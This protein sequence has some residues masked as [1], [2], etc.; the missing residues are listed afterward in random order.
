MKWEKLEEGF[1]TRREPGTPTAVAAGSRCAR[2]MQGDLVCTYMVQSKLG[3]NDFVPTISRSADQ[4]R[5][6][7]EQGPIWPQLEDRFSYFVSVSRAPSGDLFLYGLE[8]PIH[9]RGETFWNDATQGM[10]QN[11]L[12][13]SRSS[14]SGR[15]WTDPRPIELP[16]AGSAEAPG[17]LCVLGEGRWVACYAPYN[18]FDPEVNVDRGRIVLLHSDDEGRTWS[19]TLMLRF[20]E[21]GSGGAEAWVVQLAD[22][23]L[24]GTSWHM[25]LRDGSDYPCA[26]AISTDEG[27]T[28][29]P[30][31]STG[32]AGQTT[33]MTALP[34]GGA[35]FL[36]C[37]RQ[38]N[39][40][41]IAMA[42]VDPTETDFGV[43]HQE[44]VWRAKRVRQGE[45]SADHSAWQEFAFGEPSAVLLADRE[46]LVTFW[47][48]QPAG[49]GIM[50]VR[51]RLL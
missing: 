51:L 35:L 23:R 8:I 28:W 7:V 47:T 24:L 14:D 19:H 3:I 43:I 38:A 5:T 42:H 22:G 40:V 2:T 30:T 12:A 26:Y 49:Q 45:G 36:Y 6:W 16:T 21:P 4:G 50:Y 13:W 39:D 48:M 10:K 32:I 1:V 46:V 27:E 11:R 31:R 17:P 41:G 44:M 33:A 29:S 18:S 34:G 37:V 15:T 20:L 25:N 9:E